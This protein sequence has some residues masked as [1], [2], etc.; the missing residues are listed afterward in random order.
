MPVVALVTGRHVS[1]SG[2]RSVRPSA[3]PLCQ[4]TPLCVPQFGGLSVDPLPLL[5]FQAAVTRE[6]DVILREMEEVEGMTE[7]VIFD[8]LHEVA[9]VGTP[10]A[11]LGFQLNTAGTHL[12]TVSV[13]DNLM[14]GAASQA[15]QN[16]N[17]AFGWDNA[18]GLN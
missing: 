17:L 10:L 5:L 15:I 3:A 6:R 12:V 14:K 13:L 7:E 4:R 16:I 1:S 8:L 2:A 11:R 18:L 9:Y